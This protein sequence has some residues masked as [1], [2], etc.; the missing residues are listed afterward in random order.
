MSKSTH[1]RSRRLQAPHPPAEQVARRPLKSLV[2]DKTLWPRI[3]LDEDRV[4]HFVHL[5]EAGVALPPIKAQRNS[6]VVLGGWH[7]Y[8]ACLRAGRDEY[9]VDLVDVSDEERLLFAYNDDV[10]AAMA[11]CDADVESVACRLYAQRAANLANGELVN[12]AAL[13]RDLQRPQRTVARWVEDLVD[14]AEAARD[15]ARVARELAV[16]ALLAT[17]RSKRKVATLFEISEM[18]VRRISQVAILSHL[19]SDPTIQEARQILRALSRDGIAEPDVEQALDWITEQEEALL[20]QAGAEVRACFGDISTSSIE[21]HGAERTAEDETTSLVSEAAATE[22]DP[23]ADSME[24]DEQLRERDHDVERLRD[25]I[26]EALY[27]LDTVA[28][29]VLRVIERDVWRERMSRFDWHTR[30]SFASFREFV[31]AARPG[32]LGHT[33]DSLRDLCRRRPDVLEAIDRA[34]QPV[35]AVTNDPAIGSDDRSTSA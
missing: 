14:E 17:G 10:A 29:V 23:R 35:A 16:H 3:D 15:R 1:A 19:N 27:A 21:E 5:L 26:E 33:I 30:T 9:L 8:H 32:G 13:A 20:S 4:N 2:L 22:A 25:A 18:E 7:T 6:L 34:M 24:W 11:Y 12:V 28:V 31:E